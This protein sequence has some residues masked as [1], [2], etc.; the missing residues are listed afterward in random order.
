MLFDNVKG[1]CDTPQRFW[2]ENRG[3]YGVVG[4]VTGVTIKKARSQPGDGD[5]VHRYKHK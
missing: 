5:H 1:V 2:G 3:K 4:M